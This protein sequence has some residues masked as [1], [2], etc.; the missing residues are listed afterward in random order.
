MRTGIALGSNVGD[1]MSHLAFAK[2]AIESLG[3][4]P[5]L[6]SHVYETEA[7]DCAPDTPAFLNAVM[8]FGYS[9]DLFALLASLQKLEVAAGRPAVH[10]RN[11]PRPL[12]LDIL[13]SG[14]RVINHRSLKV[15]HP[16][17]HHRR[18]VLQPLTDIRPQL[19][20]PG[21]THRAES[22][23]ARTPVQPQVSLYAECF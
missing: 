9:G 22:L 5:I 2:S 8:E 23:L 14:N 12:D 3:F 6:T 16:R 21:Q 1:R 11:M 7:A 17:M 18:F 15:P 20:L 19:L 10:G 13:Y 4:G